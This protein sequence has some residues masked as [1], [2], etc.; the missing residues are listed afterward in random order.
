M[1]F[2]SREPVLA[3]FSFVRP[4]ASL[5]RRTWVVAGAGELVEGTLVSQGILRR[6]ETSADA[7]ME[8][9]GYVCRVMAERMR[10]LGGTWGQASVVDAYTIH[11]IHGLI[12]PLLFKRMPA[13]RRVGVTWHYTR[14]PVVDIEFEMDLRGVVAER[15]I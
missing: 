1:L 6:G 11:P 5:R 14:P 2:R 8:K 12:E 13:V 7:L 10:G 4:N 15:V 3:G 9:A